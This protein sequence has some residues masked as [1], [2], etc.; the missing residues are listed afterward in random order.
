MTAAELRARRG[1]PARRVTHLT[2]VLDEN[3]VWISADSIELSPISLRLAYPP[4]FDLMARIAG[5]RLR[6]R[7][8][9]WNHEPYI[10]N[11]WRHISVY[12]LASNPS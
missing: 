5:L 4:E 2:Q 3:H 10:A 1:H 11:S 9:G 7:W 6:A 12:E 8:G